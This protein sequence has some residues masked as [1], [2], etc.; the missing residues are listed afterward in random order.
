M[1]DDEELMRLR[2]AALKSKR[3]AGAQDKAEDFNA[4]AEDSKL[5][6][7]CKFTVGFCFDSF[8]LMPTLIYQFHSLEPFLS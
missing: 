2:E 5:Q 8:T 6:V 3:K 7:R 1:S 4:E